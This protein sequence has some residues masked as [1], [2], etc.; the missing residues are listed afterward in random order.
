MRH[1][2]SVMLNL[3]PLMLLYLLKRQIELRALGNHNCAHHTNA[4][5]ADLSLLA[6][7]F[8]VPSLYT[9]G[10][11]PP[12]PTGATFFLKTT[13]VISLDGIFPAILQW[14]PEDCKPQ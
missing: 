8:A 14:S 6:Q 12:T 2:F 11:E 10:E 5:T 4:P 1:V 13:M 7:W 9:D 3:I